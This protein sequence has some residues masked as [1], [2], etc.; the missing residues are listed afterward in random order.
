M[1]TIDG[2]GGQDQLTGTSGDDL[3]HGLAGDDSLFGGDGNDR[4]EGGDDKDFLDGGAGDDLLYGGGGNDSLGGWLGGNDRSYGEE[5]NDFLYMNGPL[6]GAVLPASVD[7]LLDGGSGDD[8]IRLNYARESDSATLVGGSGSD[9]IIADRTIGALTIDAGDDA[10]FVSITTRQTVFD[11]TLGSGRD[12][13]QIENDQYF[14]TT[15][16][17]TVND[18]QAGDD[19][20]MLSVD[21]FLA[22]YSRHF[23]FDGWDMSANPFAAGYFKLIQR[24]A[25]AVLQ[26]DGDLAGTQTGYVDFVVLENVSAAALTARNLGGFAANGSAVPAL[27]FAGT[28]LA[29]FTSGTGGADL[30]RGLGGNDALFGSSGNDRLEGGAGDDILEGEAGDDLL[31]GGDDND[32]LNDTLNG[33][34]QLFGEGG[35]D[36][37]F[38]DRQ[39][40]G[41]SSNVLMDGGAG[42]DQIHYLAGSGPHDLTVHG[43][44]GNDFISI[45]LGRNVIVDAG[46]DNDFVRV[47]LSATAILTLGSGADTVSLTFQNFANLPP[48]EV[49][50]TDFQAG[51]DGDR[52]DQVWLPQN[53]LSGWDGTS[54]PFAQDYLRLAQSGADT[55]ILYDADAD[56]SGHRSLAR[57]SSLDATQ[58]TAFNLLYAPGAVAIAGTAGND[59]VRGTTAAEELFGLDG[60]DFMDGG[61]GADVMRGGDGNDTYIVDN[62]GDVVVETFGAGFDAAYAFVSFALSANANLEWLST[63]DN[64]A[65]NAINLTGS[66]IGQYLIGNQGANLLDGKAGADFMQGFAGND[67]YYV[68]NGS[69]APVEAA[70]QGFDSVYTEISFGL[71]IGTEIEWLSTTSTTGTNAINLLGNEINNY[72]VGN[73]G[74][75]SL[76]GAG[77]A[78]TMIGYGGNDTYIVDQAGDSVVE[79]VNGGF[80]AIYA[81]SSF[82]LGAGSE[83]EWVSAASVGATNALNLSGNEF[84]NYVLGNNGANVINGGGGSDYLYGYGGADSFQFTTALGANNVDALMDFVSGTD[85]IALDDAIFAQIGG[86][87]ALAAGAFVTGSAAADANDRIVYNNATGQLFYDADG[88]GAGAA[89]LFATLNGS[90]AL[91]ASDFQVI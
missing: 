19:G 85:K 35:N 8:T 89:I 5:G 78:D 75:N 64:N 16:T 33:S 1:P 60:S 34:D 44:S 67:T 7:L 69:D 10:D 72:L 88:N 42:A 61:A 29:D 11:I 31:Y 25:D 48:R 54:N 79:A 86:L 17:I 83:V 23:L 58:L 45:Y 74:A 91:A 51:A 77:G 21:R 53:L 50:I 2:T 18:F 32:T 52:F 43:G 73:E 63:I 37:L 47:D 84:T 39:W 28:S 15:A 20:D 3:I 81:T 22:F 56:G 4:L 38:V 40:F 80:D 13:L 65:T 36:N 57:L 82:A 6:P 70:G 24:G 49:V 90:P 46:E 62:A 26:V 12:L 76:D 30:M 68:D 41:G 59:T 66:S 87:G 27:D 71:A 55:L 9:R 14:P